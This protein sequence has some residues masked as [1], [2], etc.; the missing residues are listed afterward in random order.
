MN[1]LTVG[2]EVKFSDSAPD[3]SF[4]GYGSV[5]G[6]EDGHGDV[7][8]K[9]AFRDTLREWKRQSKL[10]KML[11]QHGGGLFGGSADGMLPIGI[12][13]SMDEDAIGLRCEGR[14]F[15]L[16]TERGRY[17]H[18]GLKSGALDGLSIGYMTKEFVLGTKP[19]EPARTI[20]RADLMEVSV[21][22]FPSNTQALVDEVKSIDSINT[23]SDAERYAR[24][25]WNASRR[26]ALAFVSRVK[27]LAQREAG[28]V[29]TD[30]LIA[31][32][33]NANASFR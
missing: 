4:A 15:A 21:V 32:L 23:L 22:T 14:L 24:D 12:W 28:A 18:E 10:P 13:T 17:I 31:A 2:F 30:G 8:V 26:D 6:N 9:G 3:G 29:E 5:F 33:R 19:G 27:R 25:A 11:C 7:I 1:R 20:K 16:D